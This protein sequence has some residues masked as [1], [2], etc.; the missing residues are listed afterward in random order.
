MSNRIENDYDD[1]FE[2]LGCLPGEH[3]ITVDPSVKPVQK[4]CRRVPFA[5][6]DKVKL[7]LL[8]M[9]QLG[10][11]TKVEEPTEWVN[12]FVTVTKKSG[13]IRLC[14]NPTDLNRA[15]RRE[16]YKLPTRE[17][18]TSK[19]HGSTVYS[20]LDATSGFWQLKL[21]ADS[22]Y[23]TCFNTPFGRYRYVRMP[24]GISSAP[25]I[26]HKRVH[27][28]FEH[29]KGVDTSMDD[30]VVYGSTIEEHDQRLKQ[31][32]DICRKSNLK[33]NRSK[34]EFRVNSL[35]FLGDVISV[36]GIKPSPEK[37]QAIVNMPRPTCKKDTQ[38]FLGMINY[39][40]KFIRNMSEI[41]KPLRQVTETKNE[42][43]WGS[44]QEQAWVKLKEI[45]STE[46]CL[47]HYNPSQEIMITSDACVNGLG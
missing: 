1:V 42:W 33:L 10:V 25:E 23:L 29:V 30:I 47:Q 7:E 20:K 12:S 22:S 46:P 9:E 21:D 44:E 40:A 11:I 43:F 14:L 4:P 41:T 45:I 32:L 19:F 28:L 37:V 27:M 24:F 31:V 18:I 39:Q 13:D 36:E 5:L 34:C 17:E 2:G 8:R 6:E 35:T 16:H 26:Y 3:G 38:R 15:V